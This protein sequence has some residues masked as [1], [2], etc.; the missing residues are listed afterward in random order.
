MVPTIEPYRTRMRNDPTAGAVGVSI[1]CALHLALVF[2]LIPPD[3]RHESRDET[4]RRFG[5]RGPTET[6]RVI[7]VNLLPTGE[8]VP[9]APRQLIGEIAP[10]SDRPFSG[11][12][13]PTPD[14]RGTRVRGARGSEPKPSIGDDPLGLLRTRYGALPTVQS[15]DVIVRRVSKPEYPEDAIEHGIEG[16]V[17]VIAFVNE[18]GNVKDVVLE[19]NVDPLLDRAAVRAAYETQ[20]E[21]YRPDGLAQGVFVRIR[22]NFELVGPMPG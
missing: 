3:M 21:P 11:S 4:A 17:V 12:V 5:Y 6:E 2:I 14:V 13:L 9:V 8:A 16:V 15:E 20:F 19:H 1:A 22:Y 10:L 7:R 18:D